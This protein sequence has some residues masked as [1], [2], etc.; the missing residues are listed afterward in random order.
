[1]ILTRWDW[2]RVTWEAPWKEALTF[3]VWPV[4]A[5]QPY[6]YRTEDDLHWAIRRVLREAAVPLRHEVE[7]GPGMRIDFVSCGVGIE[8][9]TSGKP[10]EI[11]GQLSRYADAG[12][13]SALVLFTTC[14]GHLGQVPEHGYGIPMTM[15]ALMGSRSRHR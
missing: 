5:G 7:L 3:L 1:V 12:K 14:P 6:V 11:A 2:N 13:L 4:L 9:K 15:I 8:I 10:A